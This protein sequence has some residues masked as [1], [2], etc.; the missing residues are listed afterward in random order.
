MPRFA[1]NLTM[2]FTELPFEAR[3]AAAAEAGFEAVEFL[4]PYDHKPERV[5]DWVQQAGLPVALFNMPPGVWSAGDR[6]LAIDPRRQDEFNASLS[7]ALTYARAL[8][9]K[10][11]HC[12][13][14]IAERPDPVAARVYRDNLLKAAD[15]AGEIGAEILIEPLNPRDMPGYYLNNFN[16]AAELIDRLGHSCLRLQFDIYHRQILHGDVLTGLRSLFPLVGHVQTAAVPHRGE[17]GSGELDDARIFTE[18]DALGYEGFVGCEYRPI[19]DTIAG[20][21]WLDGYR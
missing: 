2:L 5:A 7:L 15:A 4:F 10:R 16:D 20:L 17:P 6:G 14:G 18:L 1:A 21:H 3:F 11:L 12:M 9:V 19:A 13:A 8:G